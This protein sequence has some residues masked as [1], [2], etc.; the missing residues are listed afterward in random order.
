MKLLTQYI[1]PCA[2]RGRRAGKLPSALG[3][4]GF[5]SDS[6]LMMAVK[7]EYAVHLAKNFYAV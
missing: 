4:R 3:M 2:W 7:A 1:I 6:F 5:K